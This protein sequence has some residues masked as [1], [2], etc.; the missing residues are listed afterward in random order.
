MKAG[1]V[2]S[3]DLVLVQ[4][5]VD[6]Q[7]SVFRDVHSFA[8]HGWLREHEDTAPK[9]SPRC[10]CSSRSANAEIPPNTILARTARSAFGGVELEPIR[11]GNECAD[12]TMGPQPKPALATDR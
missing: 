4:V 3:D 9:T 7:V 8:K 1:C 2:P 10:I 11:F 6:F 5:L 12:A